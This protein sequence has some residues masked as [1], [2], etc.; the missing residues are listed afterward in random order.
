MSSFAKNVMLGLGKRSSELRRIIKEH[1][2]PNA[3]HLSAE[4]IS[5]DI[6]DAVADVY[7]QRRGSPEPYRGVDHLLAA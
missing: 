2:N 4:A 1:Y 6:A 5:Q 7:R 3:A